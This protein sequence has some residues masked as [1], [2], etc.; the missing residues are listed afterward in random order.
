MDIPDLMDT[1]LAAGWIEVFGW[2]AAILTLAA[3]AMRTMLAFRIVAFCSN[4]F[5]LA[6]GYFASIHPTFVL[7]VFLIALN[8]YRLWQV[9][10]DVRRARSREGQQDL[11]AILAPFMHKTAR[12]GGERLFARGDSP[13]NVYLI[14]EGEVRLEEIGKVLGPGELVGEIGFF[15]EARAR[16][17]TAICETDCRLLAADEAAFVK[18]Y[19]QS[20]Q[21]G[22]ALV[23]LVASRLTEQNAILAGR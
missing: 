8:G 23:R 12:K 11:R 14:V 5:F 1:M 18:A 19:Y 20:P 9:L 21:L 10:R 15:T 17:L 2:I 16:T 3:Y 7:H 22:L 6:Y 13:D 4:F